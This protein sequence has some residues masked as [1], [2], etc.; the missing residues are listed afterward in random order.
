MTLMNLGLALKNMY[1][2]MINRLVH[3]PTLL[4]LFC[5]C[6]VAVLWLLIAFPFW[7]SHDLPTLSGDKT[8]SLLQLP[9][10]SF[11]IIIISSFIFFCF[12]SQYK[13]IMDDTI[14]PLS[15]PIWQ[16]FGSGDSAT[17][18]HTTGMGGHCSGERG[19]SHLPLPP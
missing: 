13:R 17:S 11:S 4:W 7:R 1:L 3:F 18:E 9:L 10:F 6:S 14:I 12:F 16:L 19:G 15:A 5:D 8:M 2:S